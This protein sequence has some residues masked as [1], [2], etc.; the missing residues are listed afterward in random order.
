MESIDQFLDEFVESHYPN[1][2]ISTYDLEKT[3][4]TLNWK[5]YDVIEREPSVLAYIQGRSPRETLIGQFNDGPEEQDEAKQLENVIKT[6]HNY[7][8]LSASQNGDLETVKKALEKGANPDEACMTRNNKS[9]PIIEAALKGYL[10]IVEVL[11]SA[12]ANVNVKKRNGESAIADAS[13]YDHYAIAKILLENGADPNVVAQGGLTPLTQ[14]E[15]VRMV[16]LLLRHG[17]DPNIPDDD[18]DLPIIYRV[19]NGDKASVIAL[20]K[21]GTDLDR[22]NKW[23]QSARSKC[24]VLVGNIEEILNA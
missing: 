19:D 15:N 1:V 4:R 7:V 8:L 12:G 14:V 2:Y 5:I 3:V 24:R 23:G 22:K 13:C 18:G 6:I 9:Y 20:I 21:A 16:E 17:A 11:I 10:E